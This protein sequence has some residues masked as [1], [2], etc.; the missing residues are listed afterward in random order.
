MRF[1]WN[2][3]APERRSIVFRQLGPWRHSK[4]RSWFRLVIVAAIFLQAITIAGAQHHTKNLN[5]SERAD[6]QETSPWVLIQAQ[7]CPFQH[8]THA[9]CFAVSLWC[10]DYCGP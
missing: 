3:L 5:Y 7:G 6:K 9:K 8:T 10:R 2:P 1:T 4:R